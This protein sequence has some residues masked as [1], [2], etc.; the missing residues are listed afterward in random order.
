MISKQ[1]I[2]QNRGGLHARPATFLVQLAG[3]YQCQIKVSIDGK[4]ADG[5]SVIGL[6]TLG[7][8]AGKQITVVA[9][10][11]DEETAMEEISS[12]LEKVGE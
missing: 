1:L 4:E 5:K 3:K 11:P 8:G 9:D 12:F 6:M 10:G 2:L 7:A